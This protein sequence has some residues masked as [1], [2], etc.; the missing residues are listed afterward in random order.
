VRESRERIERLH[1]AATELVAARTEAELFERTVDAA[2]RV[3]DF[4]LCHVGIEADGEIVPRASS[5]DAEP[6][7]FPVLSI[8]EGVAGKTYRTGESFVVDVAASPEAEP[9]REAFRSGLSIPLGD[10]GVFQAVSAEPDYFDDAD[11][12]LAELLVSYATETLAR[13][14]SE[15]ELREREAALA[16]QNERL[17][18]FASVLS[19][20]LR[21]P[22]SVATG[23]LALAEEDCPSEHHAD[24]EW[25]LDRME[26]II[27]DVLTL[28]RQGTTV[29][30]P[31]RVALGPVVDD[32]W[33]AVESEDV[34]LD[35]EGLGTVVADER[36][37]RRLFE[38]L[39]R[40][41]VE[42][43]STSPPSH[44]RED[45]VE[46]GSTS[47]P[48]RDEETTEPA[49]GDATVRVVPLEE[50]GFAVADDGPGIPEGERERIFEGGYSTAE[51]GTGLGLPIV[52][53]LAEAHGWSVAA[54]ESEAG[55][56][57]F[58]IRTG[59]PD[60]RPEDGPAGDEPGATRATGGRDADGPAPIDD[61][62]RPAGSDAASG[63]DATDGSGGA[64]ESGVTDG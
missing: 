20:D 10:A 22:L 62:D 47:P 31:G 13:I 6:E 9:A 19:H 43:G 45:A 7:D 30:D 35:R 40:N 61:I 63:A 34:A 49:G 25:A 56:A 51:E 23:R 15:A 38:N 46:H 21:S 39:L 42:H 2:E 36:R 64:D 48:A 60:S 18:E 1:G 4:E 50:G 16:R 58:E 27:E 53:S 52:R 17:E 32:A 33:R 55:G 57:R 37:L 26:A 29:E 5:G 54:T 14:R 24:V 3:L 41:A 28:A 11:R 8:E 12:E 59:P 44:A